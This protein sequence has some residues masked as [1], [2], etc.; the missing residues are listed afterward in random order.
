[1]EY[2]FE[3]IKIKLG[4]TSS[5]ILSNANQKNVYLSLEQKKL[6]ITRK[7]VLIYVAFFKLIFLKSN[8]E[9]TNLVIT[10]LA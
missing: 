2:F 1:M 10:H 7:S 6:Y 3:A 8:I 5:K 4:E 9:K